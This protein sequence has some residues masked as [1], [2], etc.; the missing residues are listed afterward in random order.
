MDRILEDFMKK[1]F[2]VL[3]SLMMAVPAMAK[4]SNEEFLDKLVK[5]VNEQLVIINKERAD[6]GKKLYCKQL[7]KDSVKSIAKYA[8]KYD[9]GKYDV[10]SFV[11]SAGDQLFCYPLSCPSQGRATLGGAICNTKSYTMDK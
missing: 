11:A 8:L 3:I 5:S 2:G 7:S 9:L 1:I 4:V 10:Y 6:E